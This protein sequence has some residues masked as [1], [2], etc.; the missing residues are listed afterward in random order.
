MPTNASA[1]N[2]RPLR[3]TGRLSMLLAGSL[4]AF[5]ATS[6]IIFPAL[7][8]FT[9]LGSVIASRSAT[10][11]TLLAIPAL[12]AAMLRKRW[13]CRYA[14][15]VGLLED[16]LGRLNPRTAAVWLRCPQFGSWLLLLTLGGAVLGYP[17]FLWLDP[18][19][20]F[21][22][23]ANAWHKPVQLT[24]LIT[25]P[26]VLLLGILIPSLWC[27][28]LC[29]LGSMQDMLF[30]PKSILKRRCRHC[31][32][33]SRP[34]DPSLARRALLNAGIGAAGMLAADA[35]RPQTA[36]LRPPG[37]LDD[38]RFRGVCIRCGNCIAC[39]P[40][41][42]IH[43]DTGGHGFTSLLSPRLGFEQD[44]CR[45][46]CHRCNQV[47]PSGAIARISLDNKRAHRI[48]VA[49][50]EL[51]I[52]RL[53][54]GEECNACIV[55]CPFDALHIASTDGGFST[56]PVVDAAKCNGCGACESVCPVRPRRAVRVQRR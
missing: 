4:L 16:Q 48:G 36:P 14:C 7:S 23:F 21:S 45:E 34:D 56:I 6:S 33:G 12:I 50:I 38:R 30:A 24:A 27:M 43:P 20:M 55:N 44:Y 42:I 22:G 2:Y 47:C 46:D 19:G 39:C 10:I 49:R 3:L 17:M 1:A 11:V 18:L 28:R 5:S 54:A 51:L 37:A 32:A 41:H 9:A 53:A 15:P 8:P 25:L 35:A 31:T 26:I 29:P 52:C 13:F 40:S